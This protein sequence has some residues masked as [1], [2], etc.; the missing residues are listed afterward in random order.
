MSFTD[1]DDTMPDL[2]PS[3]VKSP[4]SDDEECNNEVNALPFVECLDKAASFKDA[5]NAAFK[6]K[7]LSLAQRCYQDGIDLLE[8]HKDLGGPSDD[9]TEEQF[10][11]MISTYVGVQGNLCLLLFKQEDWTAVL[12]STEEVLKYDAQNVKALY[13]RGV[14]QRRLNCLEESKLSLTRALDADPANAPAKKEL[15]A[16]AKDIKAKKQKEKN[17]LAGAF[18]SGSMY[19]DKEKERELKARL[20]REA[21]EKLQDDYVQ[22][23]L[24]RRQEGK[25]EQTFEEYKAELKKE[26]ELQKKEKE[27]E[28]EAQ[29]KKE[30]EASPVASKA[31][32]AKKTTAPVSEEDHEDDYDEEEQKILKDAKNKGYCYFKN[33]LDDKTSALIG[34]ITPKATQVS[35][36]ELL[37][38]TPSSKVEA[39][40]WN[41]AG[42]WEEKDVTAITKTRLTETCLGTSVSLP[43]G[44]DD[45]SSSSLD[46]TLASLKTQEEGGGAA[47]LTESLER[48]TSLMATVTGSITEVK[49]VEGEAQIVMVGQGK[50]RQIYDFN[51]TLKF[52][53]T[54]E[55]IS[56]DSSKHKKF[57][58]SFELM[59]VAPGAD[60]EHRTVFKKSGAN[61]KVDAA[62]RE[63]REN[64]LS[65]IHSFFANDYLN[66]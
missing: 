13:R 47:A 35:T 12:K 5:G 59:D 62:V 49:S 4:D 41:H 48:M 20:A 17:A 26:E 66:L 51:M 60:Y 16:V 21:E 30:R 23:K 25:E 50:K 22:S 11:S 55:D 3:V 39:S 6:N 15:Q 29:K 10:S 28:E 43:G 19:N 58:G 24:K 34:D 14:S 53:V 56:G 7:D 32:A 31:V 37:S 54:L 46:D 64:T 52:E 38:T 63:L 2:E 18:S 8:P 33:K 40:S 42:T 65:R 61:K 57:K 45:S 1:I 44:L 9:V 36:P 27:K